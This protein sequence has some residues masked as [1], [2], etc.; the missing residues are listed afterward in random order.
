MILAGIV[1]V[2]AVCHFFRFFLAFY[3]VSIVEKTKLCIEEN[4]RDSKAHP[5]WIYVIS[6]LNHLMLMVNSSVNF[7]IYC[8]VG[9][10]FRRAVMEKFCRPFCRNLFRSQS[11]RNSNSNGLDGLPLNENNVVRID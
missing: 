9:S 3:E 8:A 5:P 4:G 7:I 1:V 10:K 11:Q 2:F 6:A